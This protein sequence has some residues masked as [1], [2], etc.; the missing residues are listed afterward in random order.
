M[1]ENAGIFSHV[2]GWA[3]MAEAM[4]GHGDTAY[5]YFRAY[6]LC[7]SSE[8]RSLL[9]V[10]SCLG[11]PTYMGYQNSVDH[12]TAQSFEQTPDRVGRHLRQQSLDHFCRLHTG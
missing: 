3:I 4:L 12:H 5:R 2:Q 6:L 9:W 10:A 8:I 11:G 1:K 7:W